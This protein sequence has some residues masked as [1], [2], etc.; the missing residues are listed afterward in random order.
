[1]PTDTPPGKAARHRNRQNSPV[2]LYFVFLQGKPSGF[3]FGSTERSGSAMNP[4]F[5]FLAFN[6]NPAQSWIFVSCR[7]AMDDEEAI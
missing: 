1:M 7:D 3:E 5:C 6:T 2:P 4:A